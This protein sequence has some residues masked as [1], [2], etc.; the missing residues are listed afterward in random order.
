[1]EEIGGKDLSS[2]AADLCY[3]VGEVR[4][5]ESKATEITLCAGNNRE[6]EILETTGNNVRVQI[7]GY[8]GLI[9]FLIKYEGEC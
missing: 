2:T 5:S 3:K 9:P 4:E 8:K 1:M 6:N 7:E